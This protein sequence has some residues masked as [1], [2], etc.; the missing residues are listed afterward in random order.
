MTAPR[1]SLRMMMAGV[2]IALAGA[3][4]LTAFAAGEGQDTRGHHMHGGHAMAGGP[5]MGRFSDRM[6]D[7]VNATPEQRTQIR[8]ITEAA[9]ADLKAQRESGRELRQRSI[10]LFKQPTV[11]ANAAEA[12]RKEML[13]RHD[14]SSQRMLQAMLEVSRVLT[15]E[16][17][18]Q[19]A[20]KMAQRR[21]AMQ[22]RWQ[23]RTPRPQQ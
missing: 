6:L 16:Q 1:S 2:V 10:D 20:D 22:R 4:A 23:E 19:L 5:F 8:Q 13:A 3:T 9:A 11:D 18:A 14:A 17:R 12:L 21:E 15:P 7:S